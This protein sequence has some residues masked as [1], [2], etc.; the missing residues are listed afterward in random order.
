MKDE[1][2][3]AAYINGVSIGRDVTARHRN[4]DC[5]IHKS[6]ITNARYLQHVSLALDL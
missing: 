6:N 4:S 5:H 3:K 1:L 2:W